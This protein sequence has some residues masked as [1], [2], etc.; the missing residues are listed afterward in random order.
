MSQGGFQ[1][2]RH[3]KDS[4]VRSV[5]VLQDSWCWLYCRVYRF[6]HIL[7]SQLYGML[8]H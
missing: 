2:V 8:H 4:W 5:L 6:C 1:K 7:R 3:F